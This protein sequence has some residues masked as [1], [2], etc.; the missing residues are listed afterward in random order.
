MSSA[1]YIEGMSTA[2]AQKDTA[3]AA[4][5]LPPGHP[6]GQLIEQPPPKPK[7][8]PDEL[9]VRLFGLLSS[10]KDSVQGQPLD[11]SLRGTG[12]ALLIA[13]M[14]DEMGRKKLEKLAD[15]DVKDWVLKFRQQNAR[16]WL[17]FTQGHI[18]QLFHQLSFDQTRVAKS[19]TDWQ[20]ETTEILR[21]EPAAG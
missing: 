5:P 14:T 7:F 2:A 13:Y 19:V 1:P 8:I 10:L 6:A 11:V 20:R 15:K 4:S 17:S 21:S 3:P 9:H 12:A 16:V 18:V